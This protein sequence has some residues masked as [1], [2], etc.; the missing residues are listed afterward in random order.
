MYVTFLLLAFFVL[1]GD[2]FLSF[3][4]NGQS[5]PV[6]TWFDHIRIRILFF[7]FGYS[8]LVFHALFSFF[9]DGGH[10]VV[11]C[12]GF[13][14]LFCRSLTLYRPFPPRPRMDYVGILHFLLS[15]AH[16]FFRLVFLI[17]FGF[18]HH[19]M[20]RVP[21]FGLNVTREALALLQV[22]FRGCSSLLYGKG[23]VLFCFF[24]FS[25]LLVMVYL[26]NLVNVVS[27]YRFVS[28]Y[29]VVR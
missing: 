22:L 4:S 1:F 18:R 28:I 11:L 5:L 14:F 29:D 8:S 9:C 25:S 27:V 12:A 2:S 17:T 3:L 7:L 24:Y 23:R 10:L 6:P 20:R 26:S 13:I 19:S 15:P 21:T 16:Q